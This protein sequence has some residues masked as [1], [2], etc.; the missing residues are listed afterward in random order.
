M[1]LLLYIPIE[2]GIL[3]LV[4]AAAIVL[5]ITLKYTKN[6]GEPENTASENLMQ[7]T[8]L[9]QRASYQIQKT[10]EP[11]E[12]IRNQ[13]TKQ[14]QQ[15]EKLIKEVEVIEANEER[16]PLSMDQVRILFDRNK[17][18]DGLI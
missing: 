2:I 8:I 15:I 17:R 6:P 14:I 10:K 1:Q 9:I 5:G 16:K 13:L 7:S 11:T 18:Y 4:I 12:D 3:L